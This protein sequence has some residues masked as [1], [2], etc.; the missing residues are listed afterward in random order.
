MKC[1]RLC[2]SLAIVVVGLVMSLEAQSFRSSDDPTALKGFGTAVAVADGDVLVGWPRAT[3]FTPMMAPG[4]PGD[5]LVYRKGTDNTW[6]ETARLRAADGTSDNRFGRALAVEG[7]RLLMGATVQ[8]ENRGAAYLFQRDN[9]GAWSQVARLRPNDPAGVQNLGR[10]VGLSGDFAFVSSA[11]VNEGRGVVYVFQRAPSGLWSEHSQLAGSDLEERDLFGLSLAVDGDLAVVGAQLKNNRTGAAYVFRY[12]GTAK[13]WREETKL[14]GSGMEPNGQ[15][16][17]AVAVHEGRVFVGAPGADGSIGVAFVFERNDTDGSWME[18]ARLAGFGGEQGAQFG[19]ALGVSESEL[20]VGAPFAASGEGR[21]YIYRPEP[22][23]GGWTGVATL[24][25]Q[26]L[27]PR[28]FFGF[29]LDV[30]NDLA[31]VSVANDDYGEGSVA[32]FERGADGTWREVTKLWTA[33]EGM[34]AIVGAP[35]NCTSGT[36]ATFGCDELNLVS[37]LPVQA[38]GGGRGVEVND[39]WGWSDPETRREYAIVGRY[40]GTAFV[41]VTDPANPLYV[42]NLPLHTGA[43][44]NVWRDIKVYADHAFIVSDGAGLHGMQVFDLRQLRAVQSPPAEFEETVHYPGIAS[45]HNIVINESTGFAYAVGVNGGGETCGGGLHMIDIR[46]PQ[47]PTFAGCFADTNTGMQKTGY[48]HDAMCVVYRG[49]DVEHQGK[50]ICFGANETALSLA[51]VTDKTNPIALSSA[52]YPN[53]A[54]AHQG[55]ITDDH[56]YFY[57]DDEGDELNGSVEK[58]RTLI[59]DIQ[60]LDDPIMVK[61]HFGTTSASDHNLYIRGDLMYQ[62]NYV[63]GLR[64]LDISDPENPVEVGY[65]DTVGGENRPGFAG[66]WS[67]F[68]FFESGTI[69]VTSGAEGLFILKQRETLIP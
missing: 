36:A 44:G 66:S 38:I 55:W 61:E 49:P 30:T 58:T 28:D 1:M 10:A 5:V 27:V 56:R 3:P 6:S 32:I 37:F 57:L 59:F 40:D 16:G 60:D 65:F 45:A 24:S 9:S 33:L 11:A 64:I 47:N 48:S 67:N 14:E 68:P 69:L 62:S 34:E 51:D 21:V 22:S 8:D 31:A 52:S 63:A 19:L 42:G 20:W 15:F 26:D 43:T 35:V 4:I 39:V 46:D 17:A 50:E 18:A 13:V 54:Y 29:S 23:G 41:D 25:A 53:V 2:A 12:D 7:D